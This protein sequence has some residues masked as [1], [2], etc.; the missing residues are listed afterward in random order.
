MSPIV[1]NV[2][3]ISMQSFLHIWPVKVFR[4]VIRN[5][6]IVTDRLSMPLTLNERKEKDKL[7]VNIFIDEQEDLLK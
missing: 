1:A 7:K 5:T 3:D 6:W 4:S 2:S